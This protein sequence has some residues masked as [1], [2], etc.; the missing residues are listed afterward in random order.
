L[1]TRENVLADFEAVLFLLAVDT[2]LPQISRPVFDLL[3]QIHSGR[4]SDD[5]TGVND[6]VAEIDRAATPSPDWAQLKD[7]VGRRWPSL[8]A[9]AIRRLAYWIPRV[10]RYSFQ[11]TPIE[12]TRAVGVQRNASSRE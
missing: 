11:S 1:L 6:M 8:E 10:S 12:T 7:W 2:G 4:R 3:L 5:E 9:V